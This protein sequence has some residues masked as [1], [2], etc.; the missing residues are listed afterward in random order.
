MTGKEI[1]KRVLTFDA[2][3]RIGLDFNDPHQKDIAWLSSARLCSP[4]RDPY[5][6]WG[7][8]PDILSE[9][10]DFH[11]EVYVDPFGSIYGRLGEKTKGECVKGAL[12][13]GWDAL[14]DYRMPEYDPTYE[15]EL[16]AQID[17]N[18]DRFLLAALPVG[19]FSTIRDV[20]RIDNMLVDLLLE[21]E[22]VGEFLGMVE[23]FTCMLVEK[24]AAMGFD[25][26]VMY[27]DWGTQHALM[28]SPELWRK[29][30]RPV[31]ER[32]IARAHDLGMSF[33]LHSCGHVFEIIGDLIEVGV[34]AFQFDQPDLSGVDALADN[35]GGRATFWCPVDIQSIMATGDRAKIEAEARKMVQRFA[36][37]GGGFIAKDYPAWED[38]DV[39]EEWAQWARDVFIREGGGA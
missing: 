6:E 31:Y 15:V 4:A 38:I 24:A 11:G 23:N 29:L 27:D 37:H 21:Q 33:F 7:Q 20:R 16:R 1:I 12:Q 2:P 26:V 10:P 39:D 8:Y 17:R 22:K 30:F 36:A 25:G 19:I 18:Q 34:D 13:D 14:A 35:F 3:P 32:V 5:T 28:I 9:V